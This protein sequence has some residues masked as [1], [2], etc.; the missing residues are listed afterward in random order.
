MVLFTDGSYL[1]EFPSLAGR[2]SCE[3]SSSDE[4]STFADISINLSMWVRIVTRLSRHRVVSKVCSLTLP[5]LYPKSEGR[6]V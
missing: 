2:L 4:G 6:K 5:N 3:S 1:G